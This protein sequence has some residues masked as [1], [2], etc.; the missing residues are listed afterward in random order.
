MGIHTDVCTVGNFG[1]QDRLD[2]TVLGNG[3]NLASRLE[4]LAKPNEILISEN[5]YNIIRAN[6]RCKYFDEIKVKGKS[7]P[8]KTFQVQDLILDQSDKD[9]ID[10][11]TDGFSIMLDKEKIKNKEKIIGYLKKSL[12]HLKH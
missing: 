2:Y 4:T 12:D 11:E 7:Y 8:I 1:S 9:T 6:I 5:T 10:F 3:V